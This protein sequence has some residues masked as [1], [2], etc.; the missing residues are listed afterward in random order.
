MEKLEQPLEKIAAIHRMAPLLAH[1][2]K[3]I[4]GLL[5]LKGYITN[6]A[7]YPNDNLEDV[8]LT[9]KALEILEDFQ[10]T[11]TI[12]EIKE[13][14]SLQ[15]DVLSDEDVE[16]Y[17]NVFPPGSRGPGKNVVK[18]KLEMFIRR[19]GCTL[20]EII[21]AAK[22]YIQNNSIKGYNIAGAHYF[23]YRVDP[24]SKIEESKCEEYLELVKSNK[25][26]EDYREQLV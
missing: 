2:E 23:L 19:N 9:D 4:L 8:V 5:Y 25:S 17:R 11:S 6:K 3:Q 12:T 16:R 15:Q 13:L 21:E 7:V 1:I 22:L 26:S 18:Y 10:N 20:D 14:K 24:K